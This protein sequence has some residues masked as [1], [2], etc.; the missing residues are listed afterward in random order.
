[1]RN[2]YA[3]TLSGLVKYDNNMLLNFNRYNTQL[4]LNR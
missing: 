3:Y 2:Y 1:M 4:N